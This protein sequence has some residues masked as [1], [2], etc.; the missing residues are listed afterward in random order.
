MSNFYFKKVEILSFIEIF[1]GFRPG[2]FTVSYN[3]VSCLLKRY[4]FW[5]CSRRSSLI[6]TLMALKIMT[7]TMAMNYPRSGEIISL[8]LILILYFAT[9][10]GG[11]LRKSCCYILR[12]SSRICTLWCSRCHKHRKL[13]KNNNR[14]VHALRISWVFTPLT[15]W[16]LWQ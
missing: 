6:D 13:N 12:T 1:H 14:L 15:A 2:A 10:L 8:S 5:E 3:I 11:N 9:T 4:S 7:T 16:H